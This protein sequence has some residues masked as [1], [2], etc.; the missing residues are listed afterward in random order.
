MTPQE[1]EPDLPVSGK[2]LAATWVNSGLLWDQG[3]WE[4]QCWESWPAGLSSFGGGC[5]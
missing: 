3:C 4:Q 5:H 2:S 1:T